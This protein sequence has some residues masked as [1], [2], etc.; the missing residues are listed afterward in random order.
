VAVAVGGAVLDAAEI[1]ATIAVAGPVVGG[2]VVAEAFETGKRVDQLL[3]SGGDPAPT[4][5]DGP[6]NDEPPRQESQPGGAPSNPPVTTT[7]DPAPGGSV[8]GDFEPVPNDPAKVED[9]K[10]Q[11]NA[12]QSL[13][14]RGMKIDRNPKVENFPDLKDQVTEGKKPDAMIY[15]ATGK[16][17]AFADVY[18]PRGANLN[19]IYGVVE[20][21]SLTQGPSVIVNLE[22]SSASVQDVAAQFKDVRP[23]KLRDL[24]IIGKDKSVTHLTWPSGG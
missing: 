24:Y 3:T 12:L 11:E 17:V 10:A 7:M 5:P 22:Q 18:S 1:G 16:P 15:D 14:D 9:L 21:K 20:E 8:T 4:S 23:P 19:N 13:S 6:P 2:A